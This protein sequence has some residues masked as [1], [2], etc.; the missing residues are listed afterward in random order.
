MKSCLIVARN[1]RFSR[2][3]LIEHLPFRRSRFSD[4]FYNPIDTENDKYYGD[5]QTRIPCYRGDD[6]INS[7]RHIQDRHDPPDPVLFQKETQSEKKDH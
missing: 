1:N 5:I 7:A 2:I 6:K 4:A 3:R